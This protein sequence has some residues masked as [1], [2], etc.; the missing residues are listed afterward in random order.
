MEHQN[1]NYTVLS[2]NKKVSSKKLA[3]NPSGRGNVEII[4]KTSGH[5]SKMHKILERDEIGVPKLSAEFKIA[6]V[7]ARNAKGLTQKELAHRIA[8]KD[9]IIKN[10]ENGK[11]V[12][13]NGV[14]QK[15]EKVLGTKLPRPPKKK[16]SKKK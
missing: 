11:A 16:K 2:K 9:T 12:P 1:W 6:M 7:Q 14:I 15:I 8:V 13:Q 4:R 10:Y 3:K 5:G